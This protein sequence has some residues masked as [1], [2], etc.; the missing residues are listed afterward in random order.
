MDGIEALLGFGFISFFVGFEVDGDNVL[1]AVGVAAKQVGPVKAALDIAFFVE[2]DD[3][4]AV[5]SEEFDDIEP[6]VK[7]GVVA[8]VVG[9]EDVE[10]TFGEE[11][12]VGGVVDFLA[13]K[14]PDIEV[15]GAGC[16]VLDLVLGW[17]RLIAIAAGEL[18]GFDA[19]AS[20]AIVHMGQGTVG[21]LDLV[22]Q[23]R[24]A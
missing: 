12:A 8:A 15:E 16:S 17:G 18:M 9:D 4:G 24:L 20:G 11:K 19:D 10:R 14:V 7:V 5:A 3:Q 2:D 13:T 23:G 22:V 6:V 21:F 1:D